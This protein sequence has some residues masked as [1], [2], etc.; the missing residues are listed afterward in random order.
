[1]SKGAERAAQAAIN[2]LIP[3]LG[4]PEKNSN[5][6]LESMGNAG[7]NNYTFIWAYFD[8]QWNN[9]KKFY[10]TRKQGG[11][12]C[13]GTVDYA[14]CIAFGME[15]ALKTLYQ[16][17]E[18]CGAGCKYSA[19]YYRYN[20]A[21]GDTPMV[22]AQIFF[23]KKGNETHTGIVEKFD[24]TYVYT[25]EG[26]SG[27]KLQRKT[28]RR[29]DSTIACY[30]YPNYEAVAYMFEDD[31]PI[32]EAPK[33]VVEEKTD[34][35]VALKTLKRGDKG[36]FVETVQELLDYYCDENLSRDGDFGALTEAAVNRYRKRHNLTQNGTVDA[37]MWRLLLV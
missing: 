26:N 9:G 31:S 34:C 25:I 20:G 8:A 7:S 1:M 29:T 36:E 13:D 18:S 35:M 6:N 5:S 32:P 30:G 28:Y 4:Y 10:N 37:E 14:H 2:V 19:Q 21:I 15:N 17:W 24:A 22:G 33:P 23:G 12:W 3:W 16:P 11:E 27:N